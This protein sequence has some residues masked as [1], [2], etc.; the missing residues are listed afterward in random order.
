MTSDHWLP[1]TLTILLRRVSILFLLATK[2]LCRVN[3]TYHSKTV[4]QFFPSFPSLYIFFPFCFSFG[5]PLFRSNKSAEITLPTIY[6]SATPMRPFHNIFVCA[7]LDVFGSEEVKESFNVS[8]LNGQNFMQ[9]VF[10][11]PC[12]A[13]SFLTQV[14][15]QNESWHTSH[16]EKTTELN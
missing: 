1:D 14:L 15:V 13:A 6:S 3:P 10:T 2:M 16:G 7:F 9:W 8:E 4:V 12:P 5:L 11:N